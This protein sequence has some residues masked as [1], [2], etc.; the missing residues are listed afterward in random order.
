MW[1]SLFTIFCLPP[2]ELPAPPREH[3]AREAA[4]CGSNRF[5]SD[6]R[7]HAATARVLFL[8]KKDKAGFFLVLFF[9]LWRNRHLTC[10]FWPQTERGSCCPAAAH[11]IFISLSLLSPSSD[12]RIRMTPA[13]TGRS[14]ISLRLA[15]ICSNYLQSARC[16]LSLLFSHSTTSKSIYHGLVFAPLMK[17]VE[18]ERGRRRKKKNSIPAVKFSSLHVTS[19]PMPE[20]ESQVVAPGIGIN[21]LREESNYL[22]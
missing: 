22:G 16:H 2:D 5:H 19:V 11:D 14:E 12:S 21:C 13:A 4:A 1:V 3:S 6:T 20:S 8:T 7:E 9:G 18:A 17:T 10:C 15:D